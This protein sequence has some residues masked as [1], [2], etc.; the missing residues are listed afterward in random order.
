MNTR[1]LVALTLGMTVAMGTSGAWAQ[2]TTATSQFAGVLPASDTVLT[3][4]MI[5]KGKTKRLL[6]ASATV[7]AIDTIPVGDDCSIFFHLEANGID[8]DNISGQGTHAEITCDCAHAGAF[9]I[10]CTASATAT[11]DLDAAELTN[12]GVF[13]NQPIAVDLVVNTNDAC[14]GGNG[15]ASLVVQMVKK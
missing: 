12:P 9:C 1:T 5:T 6:V 13:K 4:A 2:K 8:L 15:T 3:T 14:D 7:V 11:L 10:G